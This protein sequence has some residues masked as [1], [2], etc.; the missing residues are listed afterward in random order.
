M[1][2]EEISR[3]VHGGEF[4]FEEAGKITKKNRISVTIQKYV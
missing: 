3:I 1:S 4:R 2:D